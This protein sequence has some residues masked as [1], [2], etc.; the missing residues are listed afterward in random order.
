MTTTP[1]TGSTSTDDGDEPAS[2]PHAGDHHADTHS[3][4]TWYDLRWCS[5]PEATHASRL[6]YA[7]MWSPTTL[8]HPRLCCMSPPV[9][10]LHGMCVFPSGVGS[11][12]SKR[13]AFSLSSFQSLSFPHVGAVPV[14]ACIDRVAR[15]PPEGVRRTLAPCHRVTRRACAPPGTIGNP[16]Y[17]R[18]THGDE[19]DQRRRPVAIGTTRYTTQA[20]LRSPARCLLVARAPRMGAGHDLFPTPAVRDLLPG[21]RAEAVDD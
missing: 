18:R 6:R 10:L 5:R 1:Q 20:L 2:E 17:V 4:F 15:V 12:S 19:K 8:S 3:H 7:R 13:V 21:R 9:P 11:S 14:Y 16:G